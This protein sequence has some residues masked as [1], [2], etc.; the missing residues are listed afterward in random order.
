MAAFEKLGVC[1]CVCVCVCSYPQEVQIQTGTFRNQKQCN[2]I[3]LKSSG[4][5]KLMYVPSLIL[6]ISCFPQNI[7][8]FRKIPITTRPAFAVRLTYVLANSV[9]MLRVPIT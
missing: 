5:C 3:P 8:G 7:Y 6:N 1:V 4:Q 9:F 2:D